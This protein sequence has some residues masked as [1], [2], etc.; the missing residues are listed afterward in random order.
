MEGVTSGPNFYLGFLT[1]L[2]ELRV[3]SFVLFLERPSEI[4]V[5]KVLV[6]FR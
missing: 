1:G 5:S 2:H 4:E 3:R 6:A